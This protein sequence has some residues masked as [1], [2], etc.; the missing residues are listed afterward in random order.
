MFKVNPVVEERDKGS[1][2]IG[3]GAEQTEVQ[4]DI[5]TGKQTTITCKARAV[6]WLKSLQYAVW[7]RASGS[8]ES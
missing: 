3:T 4:E 8:I 2:E 6:D 1:G 7:Q 5:R